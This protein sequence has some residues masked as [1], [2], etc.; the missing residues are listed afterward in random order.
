MDLCSGKRFPNGYIYHYLLFKILQDTRKQKLTV[1]AYLKM[2]SIDFIAI[3]G[4]TVFFNIERFRI[5][6]LDILDEPPHCLIY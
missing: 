4:R 2:V 6:R 3:N 1:S 5:E